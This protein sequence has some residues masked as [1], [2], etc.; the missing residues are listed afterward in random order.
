MPV[1][2]LTLESLLDEF[3]DVDA[4]ILR[5]ASFVDTKELVIEWEVWETD[6]QPWFNYM[7]I[8]RWPYTE[9]APE[10]SKGF[11]NDAH[12]RRWR[13]RFS[14]RSS[15][16]SST[17]FAA[18]ISRRCFRTAGGVRFFLGRDYRRGDQIVVHLLRQ[19]KWMEWQQPGAT[20]P[21]SDLRVLCT[22]N[23]RLSR[24]PAGL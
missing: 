1:Q 10:G 7:E 3:E 21:R 18:K 15:A 5:Q 6:G 16:R 4:P 12:G 22:G 14:T 9:P 20:S 13:G 11:N 17:A 19:P 23:A 8:H 2:E 24:L